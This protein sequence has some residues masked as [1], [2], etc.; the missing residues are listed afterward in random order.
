[1]KMNSQTLKDKENK[2]E[3]DLDYEEW[4]KDNN[5]EPTNIELNDMEKTYKVFSKS[6]VLKSSFHNPI[7]TYNYQPL[8]GA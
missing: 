5:K 4:L 1:M 8:Q 6:I 7:N 2:F 3:Q